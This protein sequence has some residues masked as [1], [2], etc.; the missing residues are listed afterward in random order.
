M[1]T[2]YAGQ[3]TGKTTE[4]RTVYGIDMPVWAYVSAYTCGHAFHVL[5][6]SVSPIRERYDH[7]GDCPACYTGPYFNVF[8]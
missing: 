8:D 4:R 2:P 6:A 1:P 7:D 5:V 3:P